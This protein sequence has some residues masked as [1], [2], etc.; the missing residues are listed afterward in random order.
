MQKTKAV[1]RK[2]ATKTPKL[3]AVLLGT[4][5]A[6][7]CGGPASEL[8]GVVDEARERVGALLDAY[9]R[10]GDPE[11]RTA[12]AL[13]A[14]EPCPADYELPPMHTS[15]PPPYEGEIERP[16]SLPAAPDAER[17]ALLDHRNNC[18]IGESVLRRIP[19]EMAGMRE[20]LEDYPDYADALERGIGA[21]T[22]DEAAE[23]AAAVREVASD[24]DDDTLR[25]RYTAVNVGVGGAVAEVREMRL[26]AR[27]RGTGVNPG[28][29]PRDPDAL[30]ARAKPWTR[31]IETRTRAVEFI[32]A[33]NDFQR[34]LYEGP[35]AQ[36]PDLAAPG[37]D[38]PTGRWTGRYRRLS[39][40]AETPQDIEITIR[41]D[42]GASV[43][44]PAER[45][46]DRCRGELEDG[47]PSGTAG[48]TV[49]YQERI[50]SGRCT[51]DAEVVLER[52][53]PDRMRYRW[54]RPGFT[55]YSW[56]GE[57]TRG[58]PTD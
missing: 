34:R 40:S 15:G 39:L 48:R 25:A 53:G 17:W 27:F 42:G 35:D 14:M 2:S 47:E 55:T 37:W 13:A 8:R 46:Q 52:T 19:R 41:A 22:A 4:A 50:T 32:V 24:N 18:Q 54:R 7:A 5:L 3:L 56:V 11:E 57:L 30:E 16:A 36:D 6:A 43:E 38:P 20:A 45:S 33:R 51:T 31:I 28:G 26:A 9:D 21:L 23:I 58:E 44:Y 1:R 29:I 49:T 12:E 10:S